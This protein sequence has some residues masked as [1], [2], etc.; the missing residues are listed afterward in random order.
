MLET[1]PRRTMDGAIFYL[2]LIF[3]DFTHGLRYDGANNLQPYM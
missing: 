2:V 3:I 1:D